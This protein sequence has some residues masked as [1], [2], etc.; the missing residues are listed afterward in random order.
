LASNGTQDTGA[1]RKW[2]LLAGVF[3]STGSVPVAVH[4]YVDSAPLA[5]VVL[6]LGITVACACMAGLVL[7]HY[8]PVRGDLHGQ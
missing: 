8:P 7:H 1:L 3:V 5:L 6:L 2:L 4:L